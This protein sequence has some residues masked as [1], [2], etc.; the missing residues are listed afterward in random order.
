[1][2]L[3]NARARG[4]RGR[5]GLSLVELVIG[6]SIMVILGMSLASS[7]AAMRDMT[8]SSG[9]QE[10]LQTRARRAMDR[11]A[12]D[13]RLAA[14]ITFTGVG[15]PLTYPLIYGSGPV[16]PDYLAQDHAFEA[17]PKL[18][19]PGDSDF[20]PDV[21]LLMVLPDDADGDG[22]PDFDLATGEL[23]WDLDGRV[24]YTRRPGA[25]GRPSLMRTVDGGVS[26]IVVR[27]LELLQFDVNSP[28]N[29]TIPLSTVRVR[30]GLRA[31]DDD[32]RVHRYMSEFLVR[33]RSHD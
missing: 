17:T 29:P 26:Q 31:V 22:A 6:S 21:G 10:Q 5:A 32:G 25:D 18:A 33:M 19:Q 15:A 27:D 23:L 11:I 2:R 30:L 24:S 9:T 12:S 1:M 20:G 14:P 7:N 28:A 4:A 8:F 16:N 13:L 3:G